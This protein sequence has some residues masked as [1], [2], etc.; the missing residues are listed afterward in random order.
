MIMSSIFKKRNKNNPDNNIYEKLESIKEPP[1]PKKCIYDD[2]IEMHLITDI[3]LDNMLLIL[4]DIEKETIDPILMRY[5]SKLKVNRNNV[6][7]HRK[8]LQYCSFSLAEILVIYYDK[9]FEKCEKII[10]RM[11]K[12]NYNCECCEK[13]FEEY[14]KIKQNNDNNN[15]L[16]SRI[17]ICL[18]HDS[19]NDFECCHNYKHFHS[20]KY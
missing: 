12:Y 6:K 13:I 19:K 5:I 14:Q 11:K 2:F 10:K 7:Y 20:D 9:C 18:T 17:K 1:V 8:F 3:I 4:F 16:H 15:D